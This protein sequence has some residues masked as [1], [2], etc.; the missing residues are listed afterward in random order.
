MIGVLSH[1][2]LDR[3]EHGGD[4]LGW[5]PGRSSPC[6]VNISEGREGEAEKEQGTSTLGPG[7][8]TISDSP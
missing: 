1:Q 2:G 4:A 7:N 3:D 5:A 8:T 6:T